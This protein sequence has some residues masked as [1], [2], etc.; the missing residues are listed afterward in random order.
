MS[1]YSLAT[2]FSHLPAMMRILFTTPLPLHT[3][4]P[5]KY[6]R[7]RNFFISAS[8]PVSFEVMS[9]CF[10]RRRAFHIFDFPFFEENFFSTRIV[11]K[12]PAN[13]TEANLIDFRLFFVSPNRAF[14]FI[15]G[16]KIHFPFSEERNKQKK[17]FH[18]STHDK[19]FHSLGH[20]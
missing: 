14:V 16:G 9:H 6:P 13:K 7:S 10:S 17:T 11:I 20:R 4:H 2:L 19:Y 3:L 12:E 1:R 18:S 8:F 5:R 15:W